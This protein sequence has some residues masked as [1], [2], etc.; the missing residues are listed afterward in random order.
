MLRSCSAVGAAVPV[1]TG[2]E[3][4]CFFLPSA[5]QVLGTNYHEALTELMGGADKVPVEYGGKLVVPGIFASTLNTKAVHAGKKHSVAVRCSAGQGMRVRW[6]SDPADIEFTVVAIT[7]SA[8]KLGAVVLDPSKHAEASDA[9]VV[10]PKQAHPNSKTVTVQCLV[11]AADVKEDTVFVATWDNS[12]GWNQRIVRF[13]A[14]NLPTAAEAADAYA[15]ELEEYGIPTDQAA[16]ALRERGFA[17][18]A[19]EVEAAAASGTT[20]GG[21][22]SGSAAAAAASSAAPADA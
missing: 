13:F 21:A 20:T 14:G 7:G 10:Y 9:T 5:P 6:I 3:C 19:A 4:K 1:Q 18:K 8:D 15:K 22:E 16:K 12:A 17:A 11:E 2:L